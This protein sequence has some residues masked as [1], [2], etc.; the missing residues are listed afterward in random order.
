MDID[1]ELIKKQ[2]KSWVD[3]VSDDLPEKTY[4]SIDEIVDKITELV[5]EQLK[6]KEQ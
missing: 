6:T 5:L 4:F 3:K 1:K 2:Y